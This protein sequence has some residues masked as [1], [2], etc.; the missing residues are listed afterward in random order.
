MA[1]MATKSVTA[2]EAKNEFGRLLDT[3]I[4]GASV[5]ITKHDAPRAVLMS[6]EA[7]NALSA[8]GERQLNSLTEEFDELL[9]RQQTSRAKAG[10]RAAFA[11]SSRNLGRAAVAAARSRGR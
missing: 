2:T 1:D 10:M 11:A 7:F 5:V 4:Q 8:A 6:I 9:A 3:V